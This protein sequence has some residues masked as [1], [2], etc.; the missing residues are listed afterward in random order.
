MKRIYLVAIPLAVS[1]M[2]ATDCGQIIKDPGFDL[3]CGDRLCDWKTEKGEIARVPTW[4]AGD[5]GVQLLGDDVL[6]TQA[7]PVT[8]T[9]STCIEFS[10]LTD[11]ALDADVHLQ[12]DVFGDGVI[13][14]DQPIPTASWAPVSYLVKIDAP[15]NGI[16][17]RLAKRGG[18]HAVLAEIKA[19]TRPADDCT[20]AGLT[21]PPRPNGGWCHA[22]ADCA[23]GVCGGPSND[24]AILFPAGACSS[25]TS[26]AQCTNG[27]VCG[28]DDA[29]PSALTP[30]RACIPPASRALGELCAEDAECA[31]GICHQTCSTCRDDAS[32]TSGETCTAADQQFAGAN[33]TTYVSAATY[34]CDPGQHKRAP[35]ETCFRDDDCASSSCVG[36]RNV[37]T[38]VDVLHGGDGRAC[39]TDLDCPETSDLT[40]TPCLTVGIAGGTCR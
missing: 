10:M 28:V 17:F 37:Q 12:F 18:G 14:Y 2:G 31:T 33:G 16:T 21:L 7:T 8:S 23:S 26:D 1:Q 40:H 34:E 29:L 32:C 6:I 11:V 3:W 36:S 13:D 4:H 38:C 30:F 15:W 25:C 35:G 5:D 24:P 22:G 27:F 19:Q 20:G 9:D 39:T